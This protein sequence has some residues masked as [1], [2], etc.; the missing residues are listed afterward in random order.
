LKEEGILESGRKRLSLKNM[1][2]LK[3]KLEELG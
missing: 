1:Q 3:K 2:K